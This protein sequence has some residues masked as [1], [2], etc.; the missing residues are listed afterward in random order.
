MTDK[1]YNNI[2]IPDMDIKLTVNVKQKDKD[3]NI[4]KEEEVE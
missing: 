4:I 1:P 2:T 3:G